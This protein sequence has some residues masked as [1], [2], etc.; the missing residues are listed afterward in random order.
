MGANSEL[1]TE[2]AISHKASFGLAGIITN[3]SSPVEIGEIGSVVSASPGI[4]A[5]GPLVLTNGG[6][7]IARGEHGIYFCRQGDQ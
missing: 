1:F 7:I 4:E 2:G 5:E 6:S 3:G